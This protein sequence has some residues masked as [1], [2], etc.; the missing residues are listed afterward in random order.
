MHNDV[1]FLIVDISH[2]SLPQTRGPRVPSGFLGFQSLGFQDFQL[3]YQAIFLRFFLTCFEVSF[4]CFKVKRVTFV[5][6]QNP[7]WISLFFLRC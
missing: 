4:T 3:A 7:K 6:N 2:R 1:F 5:G